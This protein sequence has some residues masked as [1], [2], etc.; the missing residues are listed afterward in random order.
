MSN[1]KQQGKCSTYPLFIIVD[2]GASPYY[3]VGGTKKEIPFDNYINILK[4][5]QE[6]QI[7]IP[8][9]LTMKHLDI[10]NVSGY[11]APISYAQQLIDFLHKHPEHIEV[12]YHGLT[13]QYQNYIGEFYLLDINKSV[14]EAIQREHIHKSSLIFKDLGIAFPKLFVPP[15][16]SWE[17]GVTDKILA[18]YGTQYLVSVP[19]MRYNYH[20]YQWASSKHLTFLPRGELGIYSFHYHLDNHKLKIAKECL[21]PSIWKRLFHRPKKVHSYMTHITNFFPETYEFW[22]E[23]F[24]W[25]KN[26]TKLYLARDNEEAVKVY[27]S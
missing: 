14:P 9:C 13:H 15:Y 7:C 16:H 20:T 6:F 11:G 21:Y 5:A 2:D 18:E 10:N 23:L 27:E 1:I 17:S 26:H 12:G 4:L 25:V 22:K 3:E 19:A 8:I 24:G